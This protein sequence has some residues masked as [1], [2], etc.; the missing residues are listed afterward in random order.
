MRA[1][2]R[3]FA[4]LDPALRAQI[5]TSPFIGL[6]RGGWEGRQRSGVQAYPAEP[7]N[8]PPSPPPG[9]PN[10]KKASPLNAVFCGPY[11][12]SLV[13][14][15]DTRLGPVYD[16]LGHGRAAACESLVVPI[17]KGNDLAP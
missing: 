10:F 6:G 9:A 5:L 11:S 4:A 1:R 16:A 2:V 15:A 13:R 8:G 3:C 7:F 17:V 14:D 12:G